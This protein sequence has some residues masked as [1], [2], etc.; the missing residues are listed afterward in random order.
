MASQANASSQ[1][2]SLKVDV[3]IQ[4]EIGG[5]PLDKYILKL[6]TDKQTGEMRA[7]IQGYGESPLL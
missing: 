4:L 2:M 5:R 1:N 7:A 6:V 3:P